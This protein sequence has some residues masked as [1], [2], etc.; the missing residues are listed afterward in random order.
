MAYFEKSGPKENF[1][2]PKEHQYKE[3]RLDW[4]EYFKNEL[5]H[6]GRLSQNENLCAMHSVNLF[7]GGVI[8]SRPQEFIYV[9]AAITKRS[10]LDTMKDIERRGVNLSNLRYIVYDKLKDTWYSLQ[11]ENE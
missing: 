10:P 11:L 6:T 2:E 3:K 5:W 1:P 8:F 9:Y 4:E 7:F